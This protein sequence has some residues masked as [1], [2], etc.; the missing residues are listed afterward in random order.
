M[1]ILALLQWVIGHWSQLAAGFSSLA[2]IALFFMNGS[3]AKELRLLKDFI[4]SLDVSQPNGPINVGDDSA[5]ALAKLAK[6][7]I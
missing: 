7:K 3:A 5:A 2:S 6:P 4:N 1:S